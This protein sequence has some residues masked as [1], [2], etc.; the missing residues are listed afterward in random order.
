MRIVTCNCLTQHSTEQNSSDSF[1]CYLPDKHHSS[2]DVYW[3]TDRSPQLY[4]ASVLAKSNFTSDNNQLF[5]VMLLLLLL[6]LLL[7]PPTRRLSPVYTIQPVVKPVWQPVV[8]CIQI[9]NRLSN[10]FDNVWQPVWQPVVIPVG[11][12]FTRY[13]RLSNRLYRVNG[14]L[15]F[16]RCLSVSLSVSNFAQKLPKAFA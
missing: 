4:H 10:G 11:C 9:S 14:V 5:K 2:D 7:L 6:L 12:L 1:R 8:S 13:N 16:R 3:R 15:W